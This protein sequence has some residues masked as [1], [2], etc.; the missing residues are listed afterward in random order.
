MISIRVRNPL[1]RMVIAFVLFIKVDRL[2][3][4]KPFRRVCIRIAVA[5]DAS[6]LKIECVDVYCCVL[7][8]IRR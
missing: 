4:R 1:S 8:R 5:D 6:E 7:G 3:L 2:T